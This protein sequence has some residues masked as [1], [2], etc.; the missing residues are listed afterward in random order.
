MLILSCEEERSGPGGSRLLFS[1]NG[2]FAK[3]ELPHPDWAIVCEPTSL[4]AAISERGLLVLTAKD[5]VRLLPPLNITTG[6]LDTGLAILKD[7][8]TA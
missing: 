8:L 5:K 4:K 2:P 6:E 7:C 3:G 1:E